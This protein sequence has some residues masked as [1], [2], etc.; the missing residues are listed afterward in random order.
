MLVERVAG[1]AGGERESALGGR[2]VREPPAHQGDTLAQA[3]QPVAAPA[4]AGTRTGTARL[5]PLLTTDTFSTPP[6]A[7]QTTCTSAPGACLRTLLRPS[8]T[9]R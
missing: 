3:G 6:W 9:T 8:W 2:A 7:S 5:L 4:P 1:D